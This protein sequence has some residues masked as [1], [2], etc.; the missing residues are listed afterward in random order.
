MPVIKII[1]RIVFGVA[2]ATVALLLVVRAAR[3]DTGTVFAVPIVLLPYVAVVTVAFTLLLLV[4]KAWRLAVVAGLLAVL[5]IVWLVPRVVADAGEVPAG[6]PRM[7]VATC[8]THRGQVDAAALVKLVRDQRIDV[9]ALEELTDDGIR[10]LDAAGMRE[11][12]P[13]QE[14]HPEQDSSLYSRRPLTDAGLLDRPT[15]WKQVTAQVSVGGRSVRVIAVHTY[16]PAGD[17][18]R[19]TQDMRALQTEAVGD[20]GGLVMLGDFNATLDHGPMR[21]LL[22]AGL[23]DTADELGHGLTPTWPEN[24]TMPPFVQLD[25]VLHGRALTGVSVRWYTLPGTDHRA[26]VAELA[27]TPP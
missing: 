27:L 24:A 26:V 15:A 10:A 23:T 17:A 2:L 19:W 21:E 20:G 22:S 5:Q 11:L 13:F 16:Y 12:M 4:A 25:H 9:L 14:L 7:R 3:L 8:N 1:V 18:D 6:A